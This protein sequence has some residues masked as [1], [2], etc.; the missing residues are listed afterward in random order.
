MVAFEA[1][2]ADNMR[3]MITLPLF[4]AGGT[5]GVTGMVLLGRS[6][7]ITER[8]ETGKFWDTVRA[9]E[10]TCCTLLGTMETFLMK[11]PERADDSE[12]SLY[13]AYVV[14][15]TTASQDFESRFGVQTKTLF[16]M[17]EVS[18]PILSDGSD[19]DPASCGRARAG[20]DL[21]I[22]DPNDQTLGDDEVGELLIRSDRPWALAHGYIANAEAT[23]DAWR[24]GWFHSG[25]LFRRSKQ[26]EYFFV[27]RAK[28]CIRRRGENISSF[29]VEQECIAHP[30]VKEV[31]AIGIASEFGEDDLM[32]V[33]S[34]V[35]GATIDPEVLIEFLKDRSP[36]FMVPRFIRILDALP[37]T[38]TEKV[39]KTELR[40]SGVTSDTWDREAH[41]ITI[42]SDRIPHKI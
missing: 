32:V 17:S 28:D 16:N 9:T 1:H 25:D 39:Q 12:H 21:R 31:A 19:S 3:Y 5:L 40:A 42:K 41:G 10:T 26:G 30:C 14:P 27:D 38:P 8:F 23:A 34:P 33:V 35:D 22:A 36:Y 13:W 2:D 20:I 11:E 4:H 15:R 24:N 18:I 6:F 7:V 37:K 29:E